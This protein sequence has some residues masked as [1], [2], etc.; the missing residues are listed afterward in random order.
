[1]TVAVRP[2]T[3]RHPAAVIDWL[4]D[5]AYPAVRRLT[6]L[7]L[8]G[9][10]ADDHEV[11]AL[12]RTL[13]DDP[14]VRRLLVGEWRESAE[15]RV[16][17]HPYKKWGGAHWRLVALAELGVTTATPG[18]GPAIEEAFDQV[19]DWLLSQ[20]HIR[21]VPHLH[22]LYRRC[23]SQEG[24]ALWA[25]A[26]IGLGS[27]DQRRALAVNLMRWEW[28]DGG[29]NC[30][31]HR[32]AHHSSFNES[33]APLRGLVAYRSADGVAEPGLDAAIDA[34]GEFLLRHRVVE[35][36]R[37]GELANPRLALL[38]WPPYW[39]FGLMPGLRALLEAGRLDDARVVPALA[40]LEGARSEDGTWR[41]DG[42]WWGSPR[43][44]NEANREIVDWGREGEARMLTLAALEILAAAEAATGDDGR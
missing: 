37:S 44:A 5:P 39:H 31:R 10:G 43:A 2:D 1:V 9:R 4:L 8:L 27:P 17:V 36:E 12:D 28:P 13:A 33:F 34:A 35:S 40:R 21:A 19:I 24:N 41:P 23:G 22:G 14:W 11:R 3:G 42:R 29:W 32:E 6:M 18:A 25:A 26:T 38:R 16:R 30:D 15:G 7:R 20:A